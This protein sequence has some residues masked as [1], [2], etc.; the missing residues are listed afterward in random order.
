MIGASMFYATQ[1]YINSIG[2]SNR[3]EYLDKHLS[4]EN[5]AKVSF[6]RSSW[7]TLILLDFQLLHSFFQMKIYLVMEE[8]LDYLHLIKEYLQ[9]I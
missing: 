8:I 7:S 1:I 4:A 5:L 2:M 3:K 6:L 9:L